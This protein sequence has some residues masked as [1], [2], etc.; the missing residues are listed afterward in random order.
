MTG[1]MST[2]AR[3]MRAE[4][5]A[6]MEN[7]QRNVWGDRGFTLLVLVLGVVLGQGFE[8]WK[9]FGYVTSDIRAHTLS[10]NVQ[11]QMAE[12]DLALS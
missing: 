11:G 12:T 10:V 7:Q 9:T 6:A 3:K 8:F 1:Y 4:I 2:P 5:F